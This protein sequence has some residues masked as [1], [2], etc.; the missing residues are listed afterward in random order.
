M[1][2]LASATARSLARETKS[3][4]VAKPEKA[5]EKAMWAGSVSIVMLGLVWPQTRIVSARS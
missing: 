4:P 2:L 3:V 5:S 1:L